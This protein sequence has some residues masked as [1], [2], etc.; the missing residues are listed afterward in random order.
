MDMS[1]EDMEIE[2]YKTP[3]GDGNFCIDCVECADLF[4][5]NLIRPRK[6]TETKLS[7]VFFSFIISY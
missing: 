3:K 1:D 2:P 4:Q 6:G 5:L 7:S